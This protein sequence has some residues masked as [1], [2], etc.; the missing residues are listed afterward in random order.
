MCILITWCWCYKQGKEAAPI[1][2]DAPV[3]EAT[4][5][6]TSE[7]PLAST[8]DKVLLQFWFPLKA[9]NNQKCDA[10]QVVAEPEVAAEV[11]PVVTAPAAEVCKSRC[12]HQNWD[13]HHF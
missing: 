4:E 10:D 11:A 1:E 5:G 3:E 9:P 7:E 12:D 6:K 2:T 13:Q 8:E